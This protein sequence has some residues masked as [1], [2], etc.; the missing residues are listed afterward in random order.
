MSS[1][2]SQSLSHRRVIYEP[3]SQATLIGGLCDL[4]YVLRHG[5]YFFGFTEAFDL[6][7]PGKVPKQFVMLRS[8]EPFAACGKASVVILHGGRQG[9]EEM[10][11]RDTEVITAQ[12]AGLFH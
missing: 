5:I 4:L 9:G 11:L 1:H 2:Q 12:Q 6:Y 3:Y 7:P 8:V 10:R